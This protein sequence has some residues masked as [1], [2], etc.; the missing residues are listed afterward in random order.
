[1]CFLALGF[2]SQ[3]QIIKDTSKIPVPVMYLTD[4]TTFSTT[5]GWAYKVSSYSWQFLKDQ[6]IPST[7]DSFTVKKQKVYSGDPEYIMKVYN[8]N[9]FLPRQSGYTLQGFTWKKLKVLVEFRYP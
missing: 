1:M 3:S 8:T 4:S 9:L 7:V 2:S 6:N 5:T